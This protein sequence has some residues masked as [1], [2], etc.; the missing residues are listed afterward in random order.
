[1][2]RRFVLFLVL[3]FAIL[4]GYSALMSRLH[5]PPPQKADAEAQPGANDGDETGKE[6]TGAPDDEP[7]Q[8]QPEGQ[9]ADQ[10]SP[11]PA[12]E[13]PGQDEQPGQD[14]DP[15]K[16]ES[17]EEDAGAAVAEQAPA[18]QIIQPSWVTLGSADPNDPFRMLVMITSRGAAVARI[19]LSSP[20]YRDLED[21]SGYLGHLSFDQQ[22]AA[23]GSEGYLVQVVGHG[24]P[25]AKAGLLPGDLIVGLQRRDV[26]TEIGGPADLQKALAKTRPNKS[27][28]LTVLR[29]GQELPLP[30]EL[31]RRPLEVVK[32]EKEDPLSLRLTLH[33][34][35]D[36]VQ[37]T[38]SGEQIVEVGS[39]LEG[40][41]LWSSHWELVRS[42]QTEAVFRRT[43][44][45]SGLEITKSYRLAKVPEEM[46]DDADFKAYH[47]VF[48]L[49]IRNTDGKSHQVAYQLDGPTGLPVE[50]AWYAYKTGRE[51]GA[52]GLRD[53]VVSFDGLTPSTINCP[54]IATGDVDAIWQDRS[55]TYVGVDAQYFSA[56]L[57]PTKEDPAA[58]WFSQSHPLRVGEV[59]EDLTK[60]A[61]TSCRLV[62]QVHELAPGEKLSHSYEVFAGPK[63]PDVLAHYGLGELIYYGWFGLIAQP[64]S[65]I[66]H[67]FYVIVHNYGLA[68]LMLTVLVR[69]CMFPMSRK[70]ALGAQKMQEL[71]PEIKKIQEKYKKDMEARTKAQQELFRKHNYNPLSGCLVLFVQLPIFVA[72]YRSLSV[73]IELRQAPLLSESIRWC[74][75]LAAP[76]ML[77]DWSGFMPVWFSEGQGMFALGPYFNLLPIVT[78]VLF[79]VQQKMFMP[80]PTDDQAA[81]QQKIMQYMMIFI[82]FMFF[83]VA[84][85]LCIYFIA[86][87]LWGVAERKFLP[88]PSAAKATA[89]PADKPPT[90]AEVKRTT[91]QT[92][93][94]RDGAAARK[95]KKRDR[96]RK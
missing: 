41:D 28:T 20:R 69:G 88:K 94:G 59:E 82:G 76:D 17:A 4:F 33:Q 12:E 72:L 60:L 10:D 95:R 96:G 57:I 91:G 87:S 44:P 63:V 26:S 55:V 43:L 84:S 70:Q 2:E 37:P 75:N 1:M 18:E 78:I 65:Q 19:E 23:A 68:I 39:E 64:M 53:V 79:I 93:N 90:K 67:F 62:S 85:G 92:T 14:D 47:L 40:L 89:K 27:I 16:E 11:P 3:S 45:E 48:D 51:W 6:E 15:A 13:A 61:N 71:Q 32:P 49:T 34:L 66:L 38:I 46:I 8:P 36:R 22:E 21:R 81:M 54:D 25:A 80:P 29:D 42:N 74:S 86:S 35:D 24:T 58:I 73:D 9:E 31:G 50:G 30:V 52:A 56:V 83:K 5:P 77:L 7:R